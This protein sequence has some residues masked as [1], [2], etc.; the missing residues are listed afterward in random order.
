MNRLFDYFRAT[1]GELKHVSWPTQKQIV[2]YTILVIAISIVTAVY[3]GILDQAFTRAL[4][5][6][7]N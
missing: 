2:I 7:L 6:I 5:F 1:R 4:S 3:L